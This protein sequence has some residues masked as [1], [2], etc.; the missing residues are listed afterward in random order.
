MFPSNDP[1]FLQGLQ[2]LLQM[3]G[4]T[5]QNL[6]HSLMQ[7]I[8]QIAGVFT[9]TALPLTTSNAV[10][11]MSWRLM[12]LIADSFLALFGLL[13]IL[14]IVHGRYTGTPGMPIPQFL[15][16]LFMTVF[17]IHASGFLGT[18]LISFNNFLCQIVT[19]N[20]G[21]AL[22]LFNGSPLT[23]TQSF[24]FGT[25]FTLAGLFAIIRVLFQN[26]KR[27][28]FLNVLYILS[29]PAFLTAFLPQTQAWFAFWL[30]TYLV[31]IFTQFFQLL[32]FDLGIAM[33]QAAKQTGVVGFLFAL[34]TIYLAAEI[35]GVL[36]RF[37][38]SIGAST[39]GL[40]DIL[41]SGLTLALLFQ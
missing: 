19:E 38:A 39:G 27:I 24:V 1:L 13:G 10:V 40:G 7:L 35:P 15:A 31:T 5:N 23:A 8:D 26:F 33:L 4:V 11:N 21:Q 30:R 2:A 25:F 16:R 34:A 29:G 12:V 28:V 14:Q 36:A 37:S 18:E 22:T 3:L 41:R 9:T 32:T 20:L 6:N 17:L